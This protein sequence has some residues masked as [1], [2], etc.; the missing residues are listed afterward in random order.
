MNLADFRFKADKKIWKGLASFKQFDFGWMCNRAMTVW[1]GPAKLLLWGSVRRFSRRSWFQKMQSKSLKEFLEI[2]I[3]TPQSA[4]FKGSFW[5]S[6][7]LKI[8]T[9][10]KVSPSRSKIRQS[11]F[12]LSYCGSY[13]RPKCHSSIWFPKKLPMLSITLMLSSLPQTIQRC[14]LTEHIHFS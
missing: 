10:R 2:S 12:G 3:Q 1:T 6:N 11:D 13:F 4:V 9:N 5:L 8:P 14:Q 7:D